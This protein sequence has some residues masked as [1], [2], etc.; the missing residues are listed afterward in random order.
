MKAIK[1]IICVCILTLTVCAVDPG[2][3]NWG[4]QPHTRFTRITPDGWNGNQGA[5]T[6]SVKGENFGPDTGPAYLFAVE[7][8]SDLKFIGRIAA[9]K[10]GKMIFAI[11]SVTDPLSYNNVVG[12]LTREGF[13]LYGEDGTTGVLKVSAGRLVWKNNVSGIETP[14]TP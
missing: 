9:T 12:E 11:G 4:L 2:Y 13:E 3:G 8:A 14:I 1:V 6:A 7:E 10:S 5:V